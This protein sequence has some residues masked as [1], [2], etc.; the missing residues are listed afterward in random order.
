MSDMKKF[1]FLIR[2][3]FIKDFYKEVLGKPKSKQNKEYSEM[4]K[5]ITN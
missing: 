4:L 1:Q 3:A 2:K 5:Q